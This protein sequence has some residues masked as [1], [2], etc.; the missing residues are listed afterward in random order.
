[1]QMNVS[2]LFY[3]SAVLFIPPVRPVNISDLPHSSE[4]ITLVLYEEVEEV[5]QAILGAA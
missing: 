1:M 2:G 4:T 5:I 3:G